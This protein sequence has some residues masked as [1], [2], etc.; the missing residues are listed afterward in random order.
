MDSEGQICIQVFHATDQSV[1]DNIINHGF[2]PRIRMDHWLGQGVYFFKYYGHASRWNATTQ[3][4]RNP[5]ILKTFIRVNKQNY[6]DMDDPVILDQIISQLKMFIGKLSSENKGI[7]F[8]SYHHLLC[9]FFDYLTRSHDFIYLLSYTFPVSG[10][11]MKTRNIDHNISIQN[12]SLG[13]N[14]YIKNQTQYCVTQHG[15]DN[16]IIIS[17]EIEDEESKSNDIFI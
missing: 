13:E 6:I 2:K 10:G 16:H 11:I 1:A 9:S 17:A 14:R 5:A 3:Y 12:P 8:N 15:I 7:S 4:I